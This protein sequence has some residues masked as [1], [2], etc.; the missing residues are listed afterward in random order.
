MGSFCRAPVKWTSADRSPPGRAHGSSCA[1]RPVPAHREARRRIP[2]PRLRGGLVPHVLHQRGNAGA[3]E[4]RRQSTVAGCERPLF[5]R[6]HAGSVSSRPHNR[7]GAVGLPLPRLGRIGFRPKTCPVAWPASAILADVPDTDC[8]TGIS[9]PP[10]PPEHPI[11]AI[12]GAFSDLA[13][14]AGPPLVARRWLAFARVLCMFPVEPVVR[15]PRR[16]VRCAGSGA[17]DGTG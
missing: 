11:P 15:S 4:R 13:G 14:I 1:A 10:R 3:P 17:R 8:M 5:P 9:R 7:Q 6:V 16:I 2:S 12:Q